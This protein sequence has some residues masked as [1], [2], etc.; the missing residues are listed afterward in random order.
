ML[1]SNSPQIPY[2]S[3]VLT[4]LLRANC[5]SPATWLAAHRRSCISEDIGRV[6]FVALYPFTVGLS[7][8]IPYKQPI[9][10]DAVRREDQEIG[11]YS[12]AVDSA[13]ISCKRTV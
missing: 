8:D 11:L 3:T 12:R 4:S 9:F 2:A 10:Y 1:N 7:P 5:I 13:M 6:K